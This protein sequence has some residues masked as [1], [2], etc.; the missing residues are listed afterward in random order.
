MKTAIEMA[1]DAPVKPVVPTIP[2]KTL[3]IDRADGHSED[4]IEVM[5]KEWECTDVVMFGEEPVDDNGDGD[6]TV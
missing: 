6:G 3:Y 1:I 5:A 4:E 2:K